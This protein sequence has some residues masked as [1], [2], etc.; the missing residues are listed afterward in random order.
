MLFFQG[1]QILH[2]PAW[3]RQENRAGD[4]SKNYNILES[5]IIRVFVILKRTVV[6]DSYN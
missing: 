6:N 2:G 3:Q 4:G 5:L 1:V